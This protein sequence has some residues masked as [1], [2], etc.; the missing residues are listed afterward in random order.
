VLCGCRCAWPPTCLSALSGCAQPLTNSADAL[1]SF[2]TFLTHCSNA[3]TARASTTKHSW[4]AR[5]SL[6][7]RHGA[8]VIQ[9]TGA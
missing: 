7:G 5:C 6:R 1:F 2:Q 9:Q 3:L 8:D 4:H